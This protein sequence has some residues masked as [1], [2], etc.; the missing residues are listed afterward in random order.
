[1]Q[2]K[3]EDS[4]TNKEK[5]LLWENEERFWVEKNNWRVGANIWIPMIKSNILVDNKN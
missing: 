1:M 2:C 4:K 5:S 3:G